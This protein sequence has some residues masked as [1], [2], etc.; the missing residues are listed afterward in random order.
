M[1]IEETKISVVEG[2]TVL[3]DPHG[4]CPKCLCNFKG[5]DVKEYYLK[6]FR[7]HQP[8]LSEEELHK[9]VAQIT[10]QYGY[11]SENPVHFSNIIGIHLPGKN[12]VEF[13]QCPECET[14]WN[15]A[16]SEV[17]IIQETKPNEEHIDGTDN[18][19]DERG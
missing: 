2:G 17:E 19:T 1:M 14:I 8:D 15:V 10:A 16:G 6:N 11:T 18:Q 13:Y 7:A 4:T 9:Y 12:E 5:E 3:Q